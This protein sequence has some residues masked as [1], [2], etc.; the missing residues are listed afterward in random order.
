[1]ATKA[2]ARLEWLVAFAGAIAV[3]GCVVD[4][5]A[6][7]AE[8]SVPAGTAVVLPP[9]TA[10]VLPPALMGVAAAPDIGTSVSPSLLPISDAASDPL[11]SGAERVPVD[12]DDPYLGLAPP[13]SGFRLATRGRVIPPN[14]DVEYCEIGELPGTPDVEYHIGAIETASADG[15]HHLIVTTA[16]PGSE[17]D[18]RARARELG[19]QSECLGAA[20]E[21]GQRGLTTLAAN[22]STHAESEYPSGVG[23]RAHGGQ[24]IMFDYHF[25]NFTDAPIDARVAIAMHTLDARAPIAIASA[26]SFNNVTID[27]P[28][29]SERTFLATCTLKQDAMLSQ[30]VRHTHSRGTDFSV[31]FAS[32]ERDQQ[33]VWTSAD[34]EHELDYRFREPVLIKAGEGF[35]FSCSFRNDRDERLRYGIR[36]S[37]EMCIL[38]GTTWSPTPG[39]ELEQ[40]ECLVTWI[41][42]QGVGRAADDGGGFP[43]ADPGDA[44]ECRSRNPLAWLPSGCAGC[45]CDSCATIIE[46][47]DGDA[48]CKA[49]LDCTN[50]CNGASDCVQRCEPI[51]REHSSGLGMLAQVNA[52][53][54]SQCASKCGG[55]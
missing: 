8:P 22:Q 26:F 42:D 38:V 1:M 6:E 32:G 25:F 33:H 3:H 18:M 9:N 51:T 14:S 15:S 7:K 52:C 23:L 5:P 11:A 13:V 39:A 35:A 28:P 21:L 45:V 4:A 36:A 50:S 29:G 2:R 54:R 53:M 31:W 30:L 24:R 19:S 17:A 12:R 47:C 10:V 41:D 43:K 34:W 27:T 49:L 40:E 46:A 20:T 48:D 55:Q 37:D 16:E 44:R